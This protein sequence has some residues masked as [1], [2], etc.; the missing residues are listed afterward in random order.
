M[1]A[2]IS[3]ADTNSGWWWLK[4]PGNNVH[5]VRCVETE[6]K[7]LGTNGNAVDSVYAVRPVLEI[8]HF[9]F[10][11]IKVGDVVV[12]LGLNWYYIGNNLLLCK[13]FIGEV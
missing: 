10:S 9:N 1:F 4:D 13:S 12:C 2:N 5:R 3:G 8:E 6:Y 7:H 11:N